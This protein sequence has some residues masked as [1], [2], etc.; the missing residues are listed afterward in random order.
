MKT[1]FKPLLVSVCCA[2]SLFAVAGAPL[3]AADA[4]SAAKLTN[5]TLPEYGARISLSVGAGARKDPNTS[6]DASFDGSLH[7]RQVVSGAPYTFTVELP[8]RVMIE[9]LAFADSD[10]ETE[11]APKDIEITL[12]DGTVLRQSL[13]LKRPEKR[14]AV[15]QDVAVN[16]EV[17][18]LKITVLSNH[19][20]SEK[21]NWGGI[22]EIALWTP[23][24]LQEK[25]RI[26]GYDEKAPTFV[27]A[28]PV[29]ATATATAARGVQLPPRAA[30]GEHPC[31]LLTKTE[32]TE[33][34]AKLQNTERGK[35]VLES[36][37]NIA[38]AIGAPD[39][40]DP[41]G[42]PAQLNDRGDD[43]AKKHDLISR[44]AGTLGIAY[45]L[46]G[47]MKYAR[48]AAEI[49]VGYA[50]RYDAY[51]EHK[52]ANKND[53]GKVMAQRLSEAMW[54]IPLIEGYDYIHDSG[55]LTAADHQKIE[56]QLL[57]PAITF[58]WRKDPAV[59]VAERDKKNK[60]WR[61]AMPEPGN[62]K[63]VGNWL[64][65]YNSATMMTGAVLGDQN[66]LDLAAANFR[67][68]LAQGIGS[69]GMW[70]EGAIG[71]QMFALTAMVS[72]FEAAARQ[73]IDLW[74]FDNNRL[75][76]L[77]DSPL[78]YSYPDGS[79][80]GI[81]DSSRARL[82]DWSTMV[83]DYAY[84]RYQDPA[85]AYLTNI[86]PR[87]LHMSQAVYFPTRIYDVLPEP[88]ASTYPSTVFENLGYAILR[89]PNVFALMD[90]G[91]HGGVHGHYDK[92]N[93]ILYA[94][95]DG[96]KGDE[97][98]GEPVF[99][100]YEDAL[101]NE[102]TAETVAHNT[103]SVD[104]SAQM[105]TT[106][107]LLVF[108]DTPGLKVMR[109][110]AVAYPGA[111]SDRTVV[112][113][114]D[115]VI[116]L[117]HGRSAFKRTWDRSF[118]YN[119]TL[120]GFPATVGAPL[121]KNDGFQHL[122]VA[123]RQAAD[124]NWQG[125]WTTKVGQMNVDL[126]GAPGQS[127][128]LAEGPDK[129]QMALARQEGTRANFASVLQ[130]KAWP[131]PVLS[132]TII[133]TDEHTMAFE[134]KQQDGTSTQVIV[135]LDAAGEWKA[136][137]WNSDARV[138]VVRTRGQQEQ[139]LVAGGTFAQLADKVMVKRPAAGN[140]LVEMRANAPEVVSAWAPDAVK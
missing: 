46:S 61:T 129:E 128:I 77:F 96:G 3:H 52:G 121:G 57:R 54:L 11:M 35:P 7:S 86:S 120:N 136:L 87:Q 67:A 47:D 76:M 124:K 91:Q 78:R 130:M 117:Y 23:V 50:E 112:V 31:I 84:L 21:I 98:G 101:H 2:A 41:K 80:P 8:F 62:G 125:T 6:P 109:A 110:Q 25:F 138:L 12:D 114:P 14:K 22:G 89:Q 72:G 85:Y 137:G 94:Q 37:I 74:G 19:V 1:N 43:A 66:M 13:E 93:L 29:A 49:L 92:L 135:A 127:V 100:R 17:Q 123:A 4:K 30:K 131:N 24:D 58:I 113:T 132:A 70:G 134:M 75:K 140:Y 81:N 48:R 90:Y 33:L 83:Y 118:R 20:P 69:D 65:F 63:P 36:L 82:G 88:Q 55:A 44:N 39:F 111:L 97:L 32:V 26:A 40:P 5:A 34:R 107:K 108:E 27:H 103:M 64:N 56:N 116:D 10:Y 115:A 42:P 59:E 106:G 18:S 126:A 95:G 104:E 16:K 15:W 119:G 122:K 53:T 79:A 28:P 68:L 73:G 139:A 38:N 105:A 60:D 71:Y 99:H 51:P 133:P 102:W 9:R 45:T